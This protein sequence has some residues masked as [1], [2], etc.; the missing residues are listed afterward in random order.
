MHNMDQDHP[1]APQILIILW[2]MTRDNIFLEFSGN[3]LIRSFL[4]LEDICAVQETCKE[5]S[6]C[7]FGGPVYL[8]MFG[9]N[10]L[11]RI[12]RR[13]KVVACFIREP[14]HIDLLMKHQVK[15]VREVECGDSIDPWAVQEYLH[16]I[17]D[18]LETLTI[19]SRLSY[20]P[21]RYFQKGFP[22]LHRVK[23]GTHKLMDG[24]MN[25]VVHA[26]RRSLIP[27]TLTQLTFTGFTLFHLRQLSWVMNPSHLELLSLSCPLS[28]QDD[29]VQTMIA[30]LV[31]RC[32]KLKTL[33][34]FD[35]N[36]VYFYHL[37]TYDWVIKTF[38]SGL[39]TLKIGCGVSP[40]AVST[41]VTAAIDHFKELYSLTVFLDDEEIHDDFVTAI[42]IGTGAHACT[43]DA[44][45]DHSFI[46]GL[47]DGRDILISFVKVDL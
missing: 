34:I 45:N 22:R 18:T 14:Q 38:P 37:E 41:L 20:R 40:E 13:W 44:L 4:S 15:T 42:V 43:I 47:P 25:E 35:P 29:Y 11:T 6:E 21:H 5:Y 2:N 24:W 7:F 30:L 31:R 10:D 28:L 12:F 32:T 23:L 9:G 3:L 1:R 17:S 46:L 8:N 19:G 36:A 26:L 27:Q 33:R 16:L 39:H